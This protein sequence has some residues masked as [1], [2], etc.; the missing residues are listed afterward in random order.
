MSELA[1]RDLLVA[2]LALSAASLLP[3]AATAAATAPGGNATTNLSEA[4]LTALAPRSQQLFD[5]GWKFT[6]GHGTDPTKDLGF[7]Y[8]QGDFAKTGDFK[9]AKTGFDV[10]QWR[11]VNLPHDW[12]VELP[13]VKDDAQQ[14][15][16][17][18]PLG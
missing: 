18:K 14:S 7:G 2:G 5:F 13:F 15:H 16:G 17:Y 10:S 8:G 12:A 4:A 1:R 11:D 3:R 9:F 6:L